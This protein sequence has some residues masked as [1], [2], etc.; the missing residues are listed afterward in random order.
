MKLL[1]LTGRYIMNI[2]IS[3]DQLGNTLLLGDVDETISSRLGRIK[4]KWGGYIPWTRPVCRLADWI[5]DKIDKNHSIDAIENEG[6]D[7]LVDRP[8]EKEK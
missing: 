4:N 1:K 2:L 3:L 8:D 5:L 7:G 6:S